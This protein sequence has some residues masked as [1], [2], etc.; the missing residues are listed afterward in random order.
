M[1]GVPIKEKKYMKLPLICNNKPNL[2]GFIRFIGVPYTITP[3]T[4]STVKASK[5]C[6]YFL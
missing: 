4:P 2:I 5:E 6:L 3:L 1:Y